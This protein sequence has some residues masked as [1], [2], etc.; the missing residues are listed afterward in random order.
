MLLQSVKDIVL[1]CESQDPRLLIRSV[2]RTITEKVVDALKKKK[3]EIGKS[4]FE[5]A[6]SKEKDE[7]PYE[8]YDP[9]VQEA[10]DYVVES[11]LEGGLELENT[12]CMASKQYAV[13][14]ES[15]REYFDQLL[16]TTKTEVKVDST[17]SNDGDEK[18][19]LRDDEDTN[20]RV[21]YEST[22]TLVNGQKLVLNESSL[23]VV[24]SY[25]ESLTESERDLFHSSLTKDKPSCIKTIEHC[26]IMERAK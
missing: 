6:K 9:K 5:S 15:L 4:L 1:S 25:V 8:S 21:R 18:R 16:E 19:G 17:S 14:E 26:Y 22:I 12:L 7:D 13:K 23:G 20:K 10:I 24:N 3:Q 2:D 11:I